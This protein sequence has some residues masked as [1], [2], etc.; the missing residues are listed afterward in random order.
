MQLELAAVFRIAPEGGFLAF[1][2]ELPGANAQGET[3]D[4]AR[5]NFREAAELVIE[6]NRALIGQHATLHPQPGILP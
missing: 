1:V 2:E 5:A 4:E 3:L 6:G